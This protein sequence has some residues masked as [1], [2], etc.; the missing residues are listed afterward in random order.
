MEQFEEVAEGKDHLESK[1]ASGEAEH[2]TS[3]WCLRGFALVH[4]GW[5]VCLVTG[6][7][8]I[9]SQRTALT[10]NGHGMKRP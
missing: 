8:F 6:V 2:S 7:P 5:R 4:D 1:Q 10:K 3:G 9:R